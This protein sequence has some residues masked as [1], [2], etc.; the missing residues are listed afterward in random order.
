VHK[1]PSVQQNDDYHFYQFTLNDLNS[2]V[3]FVNN[4]TLDNFVVNSDNSYK[5]QWRS[6]DFKVGC[7]MREWG[8]WG[9]AAQRAPPRQLGG[10]GS[11]VTTPTFPL[12]KKSRICTNPAAMPVG[13][14]GGACP[15]DPPRLR[16]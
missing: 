9:G 10:L 6:Q 4:D 11:A 14:R 2:D 12:P 7:P 15:L 1:N 5:N 13:G 3:N 16:C 8:F